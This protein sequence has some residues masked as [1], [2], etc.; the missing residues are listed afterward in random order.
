MFPHTAW[1]EGADRAARFQHEAEMHRALAA[2]GLGF[3]TRRA[4]ARVLRGA[5]EALARTAD[6]LAPSHAVTAPRH[7]RR[8]PA[9]SA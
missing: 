4:V 3:P 1:T 8:P 9:A 6:R 7:V 5:A 2:A